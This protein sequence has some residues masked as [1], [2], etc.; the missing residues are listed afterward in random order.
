MTSIGRASR[1]VGAFSQ[2]DTVGCEKIAT[3][4]GRATAGK[5]ESVPNRSQARSSA[6][7]LQDVSAQHIGKLVKNAHRF[8]RTCHQPAQSKCTS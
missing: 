6:G 7:D 1:K 2:H 5:L 4:I 3:G 8:T